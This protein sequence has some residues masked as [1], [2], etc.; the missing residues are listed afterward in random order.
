LRQYKESARPLRDR[1]G[2]TAGEHSA[3]AGIL[4]RIVR[5]TGRLQGD[6][7]DSGTLRLCDELEYVA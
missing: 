1:C 5:L 2:K 3:T 6:M 7:L 4:V